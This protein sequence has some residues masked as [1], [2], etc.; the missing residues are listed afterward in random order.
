MSFFITKFLQLKQMS[1]DQ[2]DAKLLNNTKLC[3]NLKQNNSFAKNKEN[4]SPALI[5]C[6]K[7]D[8]LKTYNNSISNSNNSSINLIDKNNN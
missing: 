4:F 3:V 5:N 1:K 6:Q 8:I 7:Y 2:Q